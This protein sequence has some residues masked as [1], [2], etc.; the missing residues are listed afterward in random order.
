MPAGSSGP[1]MAQMR[2]GSDLIAAWSSGTPHR[3]ETASYPPRARQ[4][5]LKDDVMK[6]FGKDFYRALAIGFLIGCAGMALSVN[7]AVVHAKSA[8][9]SKTAILAH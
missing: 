4:T 2:K 6:P 8:A 9:I 3:M 1:S 7:S 5:G